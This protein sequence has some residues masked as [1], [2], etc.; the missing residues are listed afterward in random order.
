MYSKAGDDVHLALSLNGSQL[1]SS[2]KGRQCPFEREQ[3]FTADV[4]LQRDKKATSRIA[5]TD[6]T[7]M[8]KT[9]T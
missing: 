9:H 2:E 4:L 1:H 3:A 8:I 6:S 5:H 7:N